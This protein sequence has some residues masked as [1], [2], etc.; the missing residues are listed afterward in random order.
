MRVFKNLIG[1]AILILLVFGIINFNSKIKP[2][3]MSSEVGAYIDIAKQKIEVFKH[4]LLFTLSPG[5]RRPLDLLTRESRLIH[6]APNVFGQYKPDDW[7]RFWNLIFEPV[8][9]EEEEGS[10]MLKRYR[11]KREI[12]SRLISNYSKPFS[13]YSDKHWEYFWNIVFRK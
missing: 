10:P 8:M 6:M 2:I 1:T 4:N 5:R 12:E 13:K 9:D 7:G 3:I 11:T